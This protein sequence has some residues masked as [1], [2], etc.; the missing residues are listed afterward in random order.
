MKELL[1]LVQRLESVCTDISSSLS[2][3]VVELRTHHRSIISCRI[4]RYLTKYQEKIDRDNASIRKPSSFTPTEGLIH[5]GG[6][7]CRHVYS[8]NVFFVRLVL[9][10]RDQRVGQRRGLGLHLVD[11]SVKLP[12]TRTISGLVIIVPG[13]IRALSDG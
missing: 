4:R 6:S 11:P 1:P 7:D 10:S 13:A 5:G 9:L 3:S 8:R 12:P 2:N